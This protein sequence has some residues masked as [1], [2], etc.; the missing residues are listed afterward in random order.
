MLQ[1]AN[2]FHGRKAVLAVM[3]SGRAKR[4]SDFSVRLSPTTKQPR[5]A[6][7]VSKKI[8]KRAVVRNTIRRRV[9]AALQVTSL[10]ESKSD[11]VVIVHNRSLVDS[12]FEE[13]KK[14]LEKCV[15]AS[16]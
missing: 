6:V 15:L 1:K 11:I 16:N 3:R 5:V 10:H 4:G 12:G 7:V 9:I 2:R 13:L 14:Q 8:D